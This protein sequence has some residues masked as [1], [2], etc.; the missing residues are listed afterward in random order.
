MTGRRGS[1][2]AA[3]VRRDGPDR[4]IAIGIDR[5]IFDGL[6]LSG[7]DARIAGTALQQELSRLAVE[8]RWEGHS[9]A[10]PLA[11]PPLLTIDYG[12]PEQLGREIA[13]AL[14]KAVGDL[15]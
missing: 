9:V 3:E 11:R 7:S 12:S 2:G 14:F 5:L 1:R 8:Q 13:R 4:P 6:S 10:I 15:K